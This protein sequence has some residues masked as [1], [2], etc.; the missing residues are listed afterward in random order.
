MAKTQKKT[1]LQ[2]WPYVPTCAAGFGSEEFHSAW[3]D[4]KVIAPEKAADGTGVG[5]LGWR[6]T[7]RT[8]TV[9]EFWFGVFGKAPFT[10]KRMAP[11][12]ADNQ[13]RQQYAFQL[14]IGEAS[15]VAT[16]LGDYIENLRD[17]LARDRQDANKEADQAV[18]LLRRL[19]EATK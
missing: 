4:A 17:G 9:I 2:L 19:V 15:T 11:R 3:E 14:T 16:A 1:T 7:D 10:V 6:Y 13:V 5:F 8:K 12:T 18:A